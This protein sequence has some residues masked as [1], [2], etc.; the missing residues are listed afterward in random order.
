MNFPMEN[1]LFQFIYWFLNTPGVGG[2]GVGLI[3]ITCLSS[4]TAALRWVAR[5]AQANEP[6]TYAYPTSALH[7]HTGMGD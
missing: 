6:A 2:L 5:G 1:P 7:D 4:F 3:V